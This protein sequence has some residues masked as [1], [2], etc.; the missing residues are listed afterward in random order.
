MT[1]LTNR[2]PISLI[3]KP[4][5]RIE[6]S[7]SGKRNQA[8]VTMSQL[9]CKASLLPLSKTGHSFSRGKKCRSMGSSGILSNS[10]ISGSH[11]MVSAGT[12]VSKK[13]IVSRRT[14]WSLL[15]IPIKRLASIRLSRVR[16]S[17]YHRWL[18]FRKKSWKIARSIQ[19]STHRW[20]SP[21]K[22][23]TANSSRTSSTSPTRR[24]KTYQLSSR[25]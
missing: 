20:S 22:L 3:T 19:T 9:R 18:W 21:R 10:E 1:Y 11:L 8:T 24:I 15:K 17:S 5:A 7:T 13:R 4:Q 23:W 2:H 6:W 12:M 14:I 25:R 16:G